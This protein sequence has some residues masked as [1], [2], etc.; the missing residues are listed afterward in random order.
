ME[1]PRATN[2]HATVPL[3][4]ERREWGGAPPRDPVLPVIKAAI[5]PDTQQA[6]SLFY[7]PTFYFSPFISS[8]S[9]DS[10]HLIGKFYIFLVGIYFFFMYV[11]ILDIHF[12]VMHSG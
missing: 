11:D 6:L 7:I 4:A 10:L 2:S 8:Y 5:T 1:K 3:R 12:S 9:R